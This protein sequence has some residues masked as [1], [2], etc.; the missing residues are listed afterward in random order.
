MIYH[1]IHELWKIRIKDNV[2]VHFKT[3]Y[4]DN[5]L[6]YATYKIQDDEWKLWNIF[7][8][9]VNTNCFELSLNKLASKPNLPQISG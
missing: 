7:S 1:C 5:I 8:F 3:N 6:S 4:N 2:H 9:Q